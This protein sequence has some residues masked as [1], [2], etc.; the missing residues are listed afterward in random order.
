MYKNYQVINYLGPVRQPL[1]KR[2]TKLRI[3]K[4]VQAFNR[5]E[6]ENRYV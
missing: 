1:N 5:F 6:E 3:A 4:D 2:T